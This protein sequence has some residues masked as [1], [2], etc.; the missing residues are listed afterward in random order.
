MGSAPPSVTIYSRTGCHLCRVVYRMARRLQRDL[1]FQL[2]Y[3]DVGTHCDWAQR[4]GDRVPVVL[5]NEQE[6]CSGRITEN[7]LRRAVEKA[8]WRSP[9]SRILSRLKLALMRG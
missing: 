3:V 2:E 4:F 6:A 9:I 5:I 7:Q 1:P 8:R